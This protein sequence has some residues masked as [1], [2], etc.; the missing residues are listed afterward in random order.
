MIARYGERW[1][2]QTLERVNGRANRIR[3][4]MLAALV[5]VLVL[6]VSTVMTISQM[7]GSD[8]SGAG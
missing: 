3:L 7:G 5:G 8:I 4:L 2:E 1:L 6:L